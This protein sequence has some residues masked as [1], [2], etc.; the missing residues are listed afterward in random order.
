MAHTHAEMQGM[1]HLLNRFNKRHKLGFAP[2]IAD[3][4]SGR[5]TRQAIRNAKHDLGYTSNRGS[6]WSHEFIW[7]LRHPRAHGGPFHVSK[8]EVR[9]GVRRR[10]KR[11][12]WVHRNRVHA[13]LTP[14][15]T[16]FDGRPV[17][18]WIVPYLRWA[19]DIGYGGRRWSGR[20]V[21][22]WRSAAYSESLCYRMCGA[23]RCPGRCAG[24]F[25]NHTGSAPYMGAAD[26]SDYAR[27]NELMA[28]CPIRPHL[29]NHLPN[30]RVHFS[31]TGN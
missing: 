19:R 7:R 13:W 27:F 10:L 26:V 15:V 18:K 17:A 29:Q 25:T 5:L 21:S 8:H 30:D 4:K 1:Q 3:G 22:G 14:G 9:L 11:R 12:A 20:L 6:A 28:H 23:P 16:M 24:R 2:L 31:A